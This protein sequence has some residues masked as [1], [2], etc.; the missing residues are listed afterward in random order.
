MS[1]ADLLA[2]TP[3]TLV[4]LANRGLVKR[5]E[6]DLAAGAGPE[7]S[8]ADDTTVTGRFPDGTVTSL[9]PGRGLDGAECGCAAPGICRHRICLV[10]AYRRSAEGGERREFVDWSPGEFDDGSLETALG[11]PALNAARRTLDRGYTA[12][13]HRP[14]PADPTPRAELPTC[15]VRF[16]VPHEP[17]YALTDAADD[18]R[19]EVVALAVWAFRAADAEKADAER[20]DMGGPNAEG[21]DPEVSVGGRAAPSGRGEQALRSALALAD[22]LLLD[23]VPQAGPVF[24][25]SLGR[26]RDALASAALPWPAGA[27]AELA[28]QLAAYAV[29][30]ARYDPERVARLLTELH[31]RQRA[32]DL[33]PVGVL[34]TKEAPETPLRRVR[35]VA[36]GCRIGGTER[37][38]TAEVCFAHPEAG[39]ALVLRRSWDVPEDRSPTGHDLAA[40]RVLG[41]PLRALAAANVVSEHTARAADRS[42]TISRGR[43]SS[44]S[45]TPVGT[46]WLDL[47]APLSLKD[48]AAHLK[49]LAGRPPR[50]I[51]P[52]VEAE[53]VHVVEIASVGPAGYDPAAQ[54]LEAVAHD[55][56]GN[57]VLVRAEHDPLC[58]ARLDALAEAL[59]G[60]GDEPLWI[61]GMLTRDHGRTV[62]EPLAVLTPGG[63]VVPDLAPG[64]GDTALTTAARRTTDPL[65]HAME[66]AL[67]ALAEAAHHGLRHLSPT[68]RTRLADHATAL[69]RTGLHTAA[70]LLDELADRLGRDSVDAAVPAWADARIHLMTS[71]ELHLEGGA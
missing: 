59:G 60:S 66:S 49:T 4:S 2:L 54:R 5:A 56:A 27:V 31:A 45:V 37:D 33:D 64:D 11:R 51:R 63:V 52:R 62:L 43:V 13:L 6:K 48:T 55:A 14:T 12:R 36:L 7:L 3:E 50:L 18:L 26:A 25:G 21:P 23:G 34:G 67:R 24:A 22:D 61:S 29:R 69:R 9:P 41:S 40:R 17:G 65:T 8:V 10:L 1:R 42:V 46:A 58:P 57:E 16:P 70:G 32:A 39:V 35:L 20:A 53:S 47:P 71:L 44:T 28:G 19:G 38:R 30:G 15:T 68:A